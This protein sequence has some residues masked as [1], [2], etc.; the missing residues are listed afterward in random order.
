MSEH[1]FIIDHGR[2][3]S[4]PGRFAPLARLVLGPDLAASGLLAHLT[5]EQ[6]RLLLAI[7]SLLTANGQLHAYEFQVS[8]TLGVSPWQAKNSLESLA[9]ATWQEKPILVKL[10]RSGGVVCYALAPHLLRHEHA[11]QPDEGTPAPTSHRE[12]IIAHSR[13]TYA[14]PRAEVELS[15]LEQLGRSPEE[16]AD[17]P[18]GEVRRR[19]RALGV[20]AETVGHL[21]S[22]H[23]LADIQ[24]QLDWLPMRKAR[25]QARLIVA[26]IEGRYEPPLQVRRETAPQQPLQTPT[27][28]EV[29]LAV[30][31]EVEGEANG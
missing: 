2:H 17:T 28:E 22:A 7:L 23:E 30:P 5:D 9:R 21:V 11:G 8:E 6:A 25:N 24:Q 10:E 15:V 18:E 31:Q 14:K 4:T 27:G 26:A 20:D 1:P 29:A 16:A 12:E 13:R 3:Y 19:L